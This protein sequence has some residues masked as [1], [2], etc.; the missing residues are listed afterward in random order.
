MYPSRIVT[1]KVSAGIC[2]LPSL[3]RAGPG[4]SD[5]QPAT[6]KLVSAVVQSR[7]MPW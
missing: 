1:V 5:G 4:P 3:V 2:E 7:A 6:R